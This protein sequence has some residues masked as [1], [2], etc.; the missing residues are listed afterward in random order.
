MKKTFTTVIT[1]DLE[2]DTYEDAIAM[3]VAVSNFLQSL[4]AKK[5]IAHTETDFEED[6][7]GQRV[8]YLHAK[9]DPHTFDK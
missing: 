6:N 1:L 4:P 8:L 7:D 2:A 3:T 9:D 5:F